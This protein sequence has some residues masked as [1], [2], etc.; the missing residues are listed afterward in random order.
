MKLL[1]VCPAFYPA[2][3]VGGPIFTSL[4]LQHILETR[5]H[6]VDVLATP[7]G[8]S[9]RDR[10]HISINQKRPLCLPYQG[11]I[12]YHEFYGYSNFTFAPKSLWWLLKNVGTYDALILNGVWNF[13][14]LAASLVCRIKRVPYFIIPHGT[15]YRETVELRSSFLKKTF[16]KFFVRQMLTAARRIVFTTEDEKEKVTN[17]LQCAFSAFVMPN[18]VRASEFE[19]LPRRGTFRHSYGISD[20][21]FVL[22]HYGRISKKKGIE[23]SIHV[24]SKL[25]DNFP[26]LIL[27]IVG[28]D[29]EGHRAI[30]ERRAIDLGVLDNIIF[31]G[32]VSPDVGRQALV[33]A[34]IFLLPSL[35]ENFGMA[36][37]E[38]MLSS[39]PVV[40]SDNVGIAQD[41]RLADAGVVVSL[42]FE[43]LGLVDAVN[44][45]ITNIERRRTLAVRARKFAIDH[46]DEAAV[47][48]KLD[49]L[50]FTLGID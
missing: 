22:L 48:V 10:M 19:N 35:S 1:Q 18:I 50:L 46:Y 41:I 20:D 30:I 7:L 23:F 49:E 4:S 11:S 45:L 9:E 34:D 17:F 38:A 2:I 40:I 33:D 12:V 5:G 44:N 8:L 43:N 16:L 28:G 29:E 21:A 31:T 32:M 47:A 13:P 6:H 42:S 15:L 24:L 36:V 14:I 39:L 25:L 26:N 27:L 3:S 37:V